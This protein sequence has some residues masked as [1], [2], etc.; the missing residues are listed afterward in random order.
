MVTAISPERQGAL[1]SYIRETF[2]MSD[3]VTAARSEMWRR[4][5]E[6]YRAFI[7]VA[8]T[9]RLSGNVQYPFDESIVIPYSFALVQAI[10]SYWFTL[11]TAQSPLKQ[12][13]DA[14]GGN[15]RGA[16]LM[17][18]LIAHYDR[19]ND[20]NNLLYGALLDACK[21]GFGGGKTLWDERWET[22]PQRVMRPVSLLGMNLGMAEE[23][24]KRTVKTFD[25]PLTTLFDPWLMAFDP[26]VPLSDFQ[27]GN[28]VGET[29]FTS[30]YNLKEHE[31]PH[32]PYE[33]V[34]KIPRWGY[35][36][37]I[38]VARQTSR[39][40]VLG[41][42]NYFDAWTTE[43][44]RG[45]VLLEQL[46]ARLVPSDLDLGP[47][48]RPELWLLTLANRSQLIQ[49]EPADL[50]HNK[51]PYFAIESSPDMHSMMNPG[52]M[53]LLMPLQDLL[54]WMFNSHAENVRKALND[55]FVV[56]A[57][58]IYMSD[59]LSP[60]PM[61]VIRMRPEFYGTDVRTAVQQLQVTDVT[62]SHLA[63]VQ[64][65]FDLM[66]RSSSALDALM[67]VPSSRRRTATEAGGTFQLAANRLKVT[68][69][70]ISSMG[71]SKWG[72]QQAA[73]IQAYMTAPQMVQIIGPRKSD[74]YRGVAEGTVIQVSPEDILGEWNFPVHD[75]SM[76]LDP[77]RMADTWEKVLVAASKIPEIAGQY[78]LGKIYERGLRAL[79]I[80]DVAE[81][82]KIPQG[83]S[84]VH[85][86]VMPD[87][88]VMRGVDRGGLV[89]LGNGAGGA[90]GGAGASAPGLPPPG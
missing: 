83:Q 3:T 71:L 56:D 79:G 36:D 63:D 57:E 26:R 39:L 59:L 61:K 42:P 7:N 52:T 1:I 68:A 75:G 87:E 9:H 76:P 46:W 84:P 51:F 18:L 38:A 12:V 90:G 8:E 13:Q 29:L 41:L 54:D 15:Y 70:L 5:E 35:K 89:P 82:K 65:V 21:Y 2:N 19:L 27:R 17:E 64:V 81:L 6:R 31:Q 58:K 25:G 48:T 49:A 77:V 28:F 22:R 4:V 14:Q 85:P 34:D 80:R 24:R 60:A 11:F 86:K 23:T 37:A 30:W 88:E 73:L 20:A 45:F 66:Q 44:D 67:G 16:D 47:G 10:V 40:Q 33:D 69:Q 50:P 62:K 32:G 72:Q 55:M 78:D 53:E 43:R 74:Q